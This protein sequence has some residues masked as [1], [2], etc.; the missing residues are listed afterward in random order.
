[1]DWT[2]AITC[3]QI[4]EYIQKLRHH[5]DSFVEGS[6]SY[7]CFDEAIKTIQVMLDSLPAQVMH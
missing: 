6:E 7:K 1:M 5:R 2:M 4:R 3:D